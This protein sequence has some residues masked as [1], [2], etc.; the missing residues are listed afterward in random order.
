MSPLPIPDAQ[1]NPQ[2]KSPGRFSVKFGVDLS[3]L[4][5]GG[6][7]ILSVAA[8][9]P[10]YLGFDVTVTCG[11]EAHGPTD[12]H[13]MG[14][15]L[16]IRVLG[17]SVEDILLLY[18]FLSTTL[19]NLFTVLLEWPPPKE[20]E[21]PLDPRIESLRYKGATAAT[22]PHLHVQVRKGLQFPSA[23]SVG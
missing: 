21:P 22:A 3:L 19:G 11:R 7:R 14:N 17:L 2:G 18:G 5:P 13:T 10:L 6:A 12:P 8:S 1:W 20:G 15:A 23:G 4:Q 9:A 16:D